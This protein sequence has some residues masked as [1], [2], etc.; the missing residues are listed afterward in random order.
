VG[1]GEVIN[2][3]FGMVLDGTEAAE[4]APEEMLHWDVNNGIARAPGRATR[5][6]SSPSGAPWTWNRAWP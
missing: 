4:T 3:G 2:G 6:P 5:A 1:W